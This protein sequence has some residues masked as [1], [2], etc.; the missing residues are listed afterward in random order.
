MGEQLERNAESI[1]RTAQ[2]SIL[3]G[4]GGGRVSQ[5]DT[6]PNNQTGVLHDSGFVVPAA[7]EGDQ[8]K[9]A[10]GFSA[11]Y[12]LF[13]ERGTSKMSPRPFLEPATEE[14]RP[15]VFYGLTLRFREIV[16]LR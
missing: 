9:A 1:V 4:S 2:Q 15:S 7:E 8:I 13:L 10:A 5:P 3:D 6:P 12:S 11:P 14:N 16:G